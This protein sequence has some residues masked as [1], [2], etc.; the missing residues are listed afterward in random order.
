VKELLAIRPFEGLNLSTE[1]Y[2]V[3]GGVGVEASNC[4]ISYRYGAMSAAQGR[5]VFLHVPAVPGYTTTAVAQYNAF[6]GFIGPQRYYLATTAGPGG[7][8]QEMLFSADFFQE[9]SRNSPFTQAVQFGA[10]LWMDSGKV[11]LFQS[12][13]AVIDDW[14][15]QVPYQYSYN[16]TGTYGAGT[17]TVDGGGFTVAAVGSPNAITVTAGYNPSAFA[18]G[19]HITIKVGTG[20]F[21]GVLTANAPTTLTATTLASTTPAAIGVSVPN[22]T[23]IDL[24]APPGTYTYAITLR[25]AQSPWPTQGANP[26]LYFPDLESLQESSPVFSTTVTVPQ[27]QQPGFTVPASLGLANLISGVTIGGQQYYGCLYRSS[28]LNPTYTFV[29]YLT[30][31]VQT[32]DHNGDASIID[33]Y[34][35]EQINNNAY[36]TIHHDPPPIVGQTYPGAIANNSSALA[37]SQQ[38]QQVAFT[39]TN[40]CFLEK[41]KGR[42]WVF[43]LYPAHPIGPAP[44]LPVDEVALQPQVWCSDYG[45]PWSFNDDSAQNQVLLVGPEDTP[46]NVDINSTISTTPPWSPNVLEDTPMG[47]ASTGSYLVLFKSQRA[48]IVLGDSPSEFI[49]QQGFDIGCLA[50]KSITKAEGG[51]FW[52]APQGVHFFNGGSPEYISEDVRGFLDTIV[53]QSGAIGSYR[54]RTFYLTFP[55]NNITLCYYIPTKKWYTRPYGCVQ[56]ISD[57]YNTQNS[58]LFLNGNDLQSVGRNPA[59][60]LGNPI[61]AIWQSGITDSG[62]PG[63]LKTYRYIQVVAGVQPG[64]ITLTLT[65]DATAQITNTYSVTFDLSKGNGAHVASIPQGMLGYEAQVTITATTNPS[66][67]SPILI[68]SVVVTG[69][70]S[71]SL[72]APQTTDILSASLNGKATYP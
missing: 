50:T 65:L 27:G 68:R 58:L 42:L 31:L 14:Q 1:P 39:Y 35:D 19:N 26:T 41:H 4:D 69:D 9:P 43:T 48:Y 67:T 72:T 62:A 6:N 5:N 28:L 12:G 15:I 63:Q 29:D 55:T 59:T 25:R 18:I 17:A 40:P 34:S 7:L 11:M 56:S 37:L 33:T 71:D 45:T 30:N 44:I 60:D 22:G 13:T 3:Q 57:P 36:L 10:S 20:V 16:I 49:V 66:A 53:D 32:T 61:V 47:I 38:Q 64:T 46:G 21:N 23:E 52:L 54:E 70:V 24:G 51:I 2:Y 8:T